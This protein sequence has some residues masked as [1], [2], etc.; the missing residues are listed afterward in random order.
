MALLAATLGLVVLAPAPQASAGG[1]TIV[2]CSQSW[3]YTSTYATA[4]KSWTCEW[5]TTGSWSTGCVG[6]DPYGLSGYGTHTPDGQDWD[7]VRIDAGWCYK[8]HLLVP[9]KTWDVVYDR[10]G[11]SA[12]YVKVENWGYAK[13]T[14]Q[15][16][17]SCP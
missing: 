11:T 17:T 9:G 6:G 7:V 5:G 13:I 3:N 16:S 14:Y 1:C 4:F 15:S 8:L 10:R 2:G 12:A